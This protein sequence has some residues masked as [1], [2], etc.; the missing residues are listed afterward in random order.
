M[1]CNCTVIAYLL[2]D[3]NESNISSMYPYANYFELSINYIRQSFAFI[4]LTLDEDRSEKRIHS[5][6]YV[7]C[8]VMCSAEAQYAL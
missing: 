1:G 7:N 4:A 3:R 5:L 6:I 8:F 2:F